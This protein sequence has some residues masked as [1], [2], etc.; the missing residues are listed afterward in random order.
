MVGPNKRTSIDTHTRAQ[1][2]HASVGLAQ[3]RPNNNM[4]MAVWP[5]T[6]A[7]DSTPWTAGYSS[8]LLLP[9]SP[10]S[11]PFPFS[12]VFPFPFPKVGTPFS[13][14]LPGVVPRDTV[15]QSD[16]GVGGE[17]VSIHVLLSIPQKT[18][19]EMA[20]TWYPLMRAE[21]PYTPIFT[22]PYA[23]S[24]TQCISTH[25]PVRL[26][27]CALLQPFPAPSSP[28]IQYDLAQPIHPPVGTVV[29][30]TAT[31]I[32]HPVCLT[33]T[34]ISPNIHTPQYD[35]PGL[36]YDPLQP[37]SATPYALLGLFFFFFFF[38]LWKFMHKC[39]GYTNSQ[40]LI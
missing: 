11:F 6:L 4:I 23:L 12:A 1:C 15:W 14:S 40:L 28:I 34:A 30:T 10:F 29:R 2:S 19:H 9:A 36:Q 31:N 3:V 39:N 32:H 35:L 7:I 26:L 37:T 8:A 22:Y 5:A 27:K 21:C 16:V 24:T 13:A 20:T 38:L 18:L 17:W 33:G 25:C